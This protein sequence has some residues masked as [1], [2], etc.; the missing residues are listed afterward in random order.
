VIES[1][2]PR[3][4]G[5]Q[6]LLGQVASDTSYSSPDIK[7]KVWRAF[8]QAVAELHAQNT[9]RDDLDDVRRAIYDPT[10]ETVSFRPILARRS[11]GTTPVTARQLAYNLVPLMQF[12]FANRAS[13]QALGIWHVFEEVYT[14][15]M[16]ERGPEVISILRAVRRDLLQASQLNMKALGLAYVGKLDEA[17]VIFQQL[18]RLRDENGDHEGYCRALCNLALMYADIGEFGEA[19]AILDEAIHRASEHV[20]LKGWALALLQKGLLFDRQGNVADALQYTA[21]AICTWQQTGLP[22]PEQFATAYESLGGG[23]DDFP[24]RPDGHVPHEN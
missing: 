14:D 22:L 4:K 17:K 20:R 13:D 8:S 24:L 7:L 12:V 15:A 19:Q 21:M 16:D 6:I 18:L 1:A 10:T 11:P 23:L 5:A 3:E 9:F 2:H